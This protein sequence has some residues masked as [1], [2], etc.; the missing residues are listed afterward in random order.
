M[1]KK[2]VEK[3]VATGKLVNSTS[4]IK[5]T[6]KIANATNKKG[7]A[8]EFI[9]INTDKKPSQTVINAIKLQGGSYFKKDQSWSLFNSVRNQKFVNKMI[10]KGT[11][12]IEEVEEEEE[13]NEVKA[14]KPK[15]KEK[16]K[17]QPNNS[18]DKRVSAL[19]KDIKSTND[20]LKKIL[21][22]LG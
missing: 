10:V 8:I 21:A 9:R 22:K 13:V 7:E 14:N 6:V 11:F 18:L 5:A 20:L 3:V 16:G 4:G 12:E 17:A 19:E 1:S 15:S 2:V